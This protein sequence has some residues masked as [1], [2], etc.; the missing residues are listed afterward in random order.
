MKRLR[1]LRLTA[2]ASSS[3]NEMV[4][5]TD[6]SLT[7]IR[8]SPCACQVTFVRAE[9]QVQKPVN[10]FGDSFRRTL[11][12]V[13]Q[14]TR[15]FAGF[16]L[17][18]LSNSEVMNLMKQGDHHWPDPAPQARSIKQTNRPIWC[19]INSQDWFVSRAFCPGCCHW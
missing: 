19:R 12:L 9:A 3:H 4:N 18:L 1:S 17:P 6:S 5:L 2:T 14:G 7:Q 16:R 15:S 11:Y 8:L 10:D 13:E